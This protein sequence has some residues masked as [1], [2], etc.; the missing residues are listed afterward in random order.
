MNK[1][2]IA[3]LVQ[4]IRDL[5][6]AALDVVGHAG[7]STAT[8][9]HQQYMEQLSRANEYW[10]VH[11]EE[12]FF[13]D[14]ESERLMNAWYVAADDVRKAIREYEESH[15]ALPQSWKKF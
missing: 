7:E 3:K 13:N 14:A 2:E 1:S 9:T 8:L 6:Y 5:P 4:G 10:H 12:A 15:K 11:G